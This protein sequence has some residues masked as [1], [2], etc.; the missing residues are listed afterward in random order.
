MGAVT[1]LAQVGSG[2]G[3]PA[4]MQGGRPPHHSGVTSSLGTGLARAGPNGP[5]RQWPGAWRWHIWGRLLSLQLRMGRK[6]MD[7]ECG[8]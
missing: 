5:K 3:N 2:V 6:G 4:L 1:G 7:S 8:H